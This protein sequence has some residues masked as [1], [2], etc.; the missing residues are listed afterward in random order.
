MRPIARPRPHDVGIWE[1]P[2]KRLPGKARPFLGGLPWARETGTIAADEDTALLLKYYSHK[3][4]YSPRCRDKLKSYLISPDYFLFV[5]WG[6]VGIGK[7]WF[8][9]HELLLSDY[10]VKT[11]DIQAGIIDLMFGWPHSVEESAFSQLCPIIDD[12]FKGIG[13]TSAAALEAYRKAQLERRGTPLAPNDPVLKKWLLLDHTAERADKLLRALELIK[14]PPLFV[15]MDNIDKASD[16]DQE[17]MIRLSMRMFRSRRIR[18]ILPLRRTS[19][20]L[21]DRF[22]DLHEDNFAAM[23]LT[24]LDYEAML[25]LRF[26][27]SSGDVDLRRSSPIKDTD[28]ASYSFAKLY[29]LLCSGEAGQLLSNVASD[30]ARVLLKLVKQAL[31]SNQLKGLCN[32]S[33]P[34]YVLAALMLNDEGEV[35]PSC[36]FL[37]N[38]FDSE[39][40]GTM[41]EGYSLIRFR[42]LEYLIE[43]AEIDV[44]ESHTE[45][46]FQRLGYDAG[47]IKRI[48]LAFLRASLVYSRRALVPKQV[49]DALAGDI[50]CFVLTRTG[51]AYWD[52]LLRMKWYYEI[53]ERATRVPPSII[54]RQQLDE[55]PYE[56]EYVTH[57]SFIGWLR[58]EED[59]ERTRINLWETH[60]GRRDITL[61][62]PHGMMRQALGLPDS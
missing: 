36:P 15:V 47:R 21:G 12:Y 60:N 59:L 56:R 17:A 4:E 53:V 55:E 30:D 9:R 23:D 29:E 49:E 48:V 13:T 5:V 25:K 22:A 26:R 33:D 44:A 1:N 3:R 38:L 45:N 39:E 35:D 10:S 34:S 6:E 19:S 11:G 7:T 41:T 31:E 24:R 32:I 50:G 18:L 62:Q 14:G 27:F 20:L 43:N 16:E 54:E 51:S 40:S 46:H 8:L 37:V 58:E 61:A 42:V 57:R 52:E 2:I 28:G